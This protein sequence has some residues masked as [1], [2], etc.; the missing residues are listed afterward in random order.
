[1]K[2]YLLSMKD[3]LKKSLMFRSAPQEWR[4]RNVA[5]G[6]LFEEQDVLGRIDIA[7]M[8]NRVQSVHSLT[9]IRCAGQS[10]TAPLLSR[11]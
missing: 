9:F 1:M 7:R 2:A 4:D 6:E 8:S 11:R 10:D 5:Y 3:A